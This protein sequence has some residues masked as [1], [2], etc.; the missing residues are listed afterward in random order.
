MSSQVRAAERGR[1]RGLWGSRMPH[2]L[3]SGAR[4]PAVVSHDRRRVVAHRAFPVAWEGEGRPRRPGGCSAVRVVPVES[5]PSSEGGRITSSAAVLCWVCQSPFRRMSP[6]WRA[7]SQ[8]PRWRCWSAGRARLYGHRRRCRGGSLGR[9][10]GAVHRRHRA[11]AR[12]PARRGRAPATAT[13]AVGGPVEDADA[14]TEPIGGAVVGPAVANAGSAGSSSSSSPSPAGAACREAGS[15]DRE[16]TLLPAA[17]HSTDRKGFRKL[18]D[19]RA[20]V[21]TRLPAGPARD[22]A[23]RA[24]EAVGRGDGS[25]H[26]GAE[27]DALFDLLAEGATTVPEAA[28]A[29]QACPARQGRVLRRADVRGRGRGLAA[30]RADAAGPGDRARGRNA[31]S[32]VAAGQ[33]EVPAP[34]RRHQARRWRGVVASRRAGGAIPGTAAGRTVGACSGAQRAGERRKP[35][36]RRK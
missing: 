2:L 31:G 1:D 26:T 15:N 18:I 7:P 3:S 35:R 17:D 28:L 20:L 10:R 24:N 9:G 5:T 8:P 27:Y 14:V 32:V 21:F 12:R 11:A 25:L 16:G 13:S 30:G 4:S 6:S 33:R 29:P 23:A 36:L 19:E 34:R 22:L